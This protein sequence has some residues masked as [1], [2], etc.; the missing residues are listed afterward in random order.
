MHYTMGK[1][2]DQEPRLVPA[3]VT[4]KLGSRNLNVRFFPKR[5]NMEKTP[6]TTSPKI[7]I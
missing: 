5:T 1:R 3:I 4:K 6:G 2:W 7:C